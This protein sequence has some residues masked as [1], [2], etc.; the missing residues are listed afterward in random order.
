MSTIIAYFLIYLN[1][2]I[3]VILSA[4]WLILIPPTTG[5]HG[6]EWRCHPA[7]TFEDELV[8][9]LV[10]VMLMLAIT[11]LFAVLTWGCKDNNNE[12]RFEFSLFFL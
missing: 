7:T 6:G 12:S 11:I 8:I 2:L 10:Y 4:A 5:I 1:L 9:S 3:Q